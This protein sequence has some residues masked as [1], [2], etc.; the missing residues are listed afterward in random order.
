MR[1]FLTHQWNDIK[2][3]AKWALALL[4]WGAVISAIKYGLQQIP[5]MPLWAIW[6][7]IAVLS[8]LA[9]LWLARQ[10]TK[11]SSAQLTTV[12]RTA[13]T[14]GAEFDPEQFFNT[15]Y[16]SQIV[17]ESANNFRSMAIAKYP[18]VKERE[19]F[20]YKF[21]GAGLTSYL[22]DETWWLIYRSQLLLL[23]E[24]NQRLISLDEAKAFYDNAAK[25]YPNEYKTYTF[26]A[27]LNFIRLRGLI[28]QH[29][30]MLEI[31]LRGRD[32]LKFLVHTSRSANL[33]RL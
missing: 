1:D 6:L 3:N 26:D 2:G 18:N 15:A 24:A 19:E 10:L 4:L 5:R 23:Q 30:T 7:I 11:S 21:I 13:M 33:R 17:A 16:Q 12:Q 29:G 25:E 32:F 8:F 9:F 28:L 14:P 31:T 22:Y 20:C 27:W